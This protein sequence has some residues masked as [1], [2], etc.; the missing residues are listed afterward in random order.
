MKDQCA[1]LIAEA[2]SLNRKENFKEAIAK[3]ELAL[4]LDDSSAETFFQLGELYHKTGNLPKAL[5]AY[6]HA[7]EIDSEYKNLHVKI[8]MIQSIMNF[9]NPD[10]YNP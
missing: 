9:F 4:M 1:T 3:Y 5:N 2:E 10:M 7:K 6:L 8:E